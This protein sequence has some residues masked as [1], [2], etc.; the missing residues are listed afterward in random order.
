MTYTN[1][2]HF[3]QLYRRQIRL[4]LNLTGHSNEIYRVYQFFMLFE[5]VLQ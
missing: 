1:P 2:S 5:T 4:F 3:A